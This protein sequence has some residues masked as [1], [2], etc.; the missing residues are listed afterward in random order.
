MLDINTFRTVFENTHLVFMN[1]CLVSDNKMPLGKRNNKPLKGQWFILGG[2]ILKNVSTYI[3]VGVIHA[4]ENPGKAQL[5]LI[6]VQSG[7]YL[8]V[9]GIVRFEDL[10]GRSK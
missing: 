10:Y 8:G 4:L 9:D 3:S 6:E 5:E 1:I 7:S 2:R